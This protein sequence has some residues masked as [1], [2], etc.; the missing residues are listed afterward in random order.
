MRPTLIA[1]AAAIAGVLC[2]MALMTWDDRILVWQEGNF[3]EI[4][5]FVEVAPPPAALSAHSA[6]ASFDQSVDP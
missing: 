6:S 4:G 1:R 5:Q 2:A 3:F